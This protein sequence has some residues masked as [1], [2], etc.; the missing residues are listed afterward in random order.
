MKSLDRECPNS[1]VRVC[2]HYYK[3]HSTEIMTRLSA[4]PTDCPWL[5]SLPADN[6]W[7]CSLKQTII[8]SFV[9]HH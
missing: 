1:V 6:L 8:L 5:S 3:H 4:A 2:S 7:D 9:I